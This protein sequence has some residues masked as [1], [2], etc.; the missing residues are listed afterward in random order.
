MLGIFL[1]LETNGIDPF[2]NKVIDIAYRIVNLQDGAEIH[3][4]E[5]IVRISRRDFRK[6]NLKSLE[7]NGFTWDKIKSGKSFKKVKNEIIEDFKRF[8]IQRKKAVFICQNPSFDRIFFSKII[9]VQIQEE[10]LWP[11]HWLDFASMYFA[12]QLKK[13]KNVDD[14]KSF[15]KDAIA[16]ILNLPKEEKPH[17]AMRGVDHLILCYEKLVGFPTK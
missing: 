17:R 9:P 11:Y 13:T 3:S 2:L 7:I 15:S 10:L 6:S 1:D 5:A 16:K 12:L 4:F 8:Y 14:I